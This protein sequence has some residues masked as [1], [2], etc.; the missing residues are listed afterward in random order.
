MCKIGGL[1]PW[2]A[3]FHLSFDY[4]PST[5]TVKR[6]RQMWWK[7]NGNYYWLFDACFESGN[8]RRGRTMVKAEEKQLN[9]RYANLIRRMN[10]VDEN[11]LKKKDVRGEL[12][13]K[14]P[15]PCKLDGETVKVRCLVAPPNRC[16]WKS[17]R[18]RKRK[19][20]LEVD[21]GLEVKKYE[22]VKLHF[23]INEWQ[24]ILHHS[25][26]LESWLA[27][28]ENLKCG[29]NLGFALCKKSENQ[30][31]ICVFPSRLTVPSSFFFLS[32]SWHV[33]AS[34]CS[35]QRRDGSMFGNA[36]RTSQSQWKKK[37][38]TWFFWWG[39]GVF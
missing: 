16:F 23:T 8:S 21:V 4:S 10:N 19:M 34:I 6:F 31:L 7:E 14:L 32:L 38:L 35:K 24:G 39:R 27:S 28:V 33:T 3:D 17:K 26:T 12:R 29:K 1:T 9:K 18:K 37:F 25:A 11:L 36:I 15:L 20:R 30:L 2:D 22:A 5:S 13:A